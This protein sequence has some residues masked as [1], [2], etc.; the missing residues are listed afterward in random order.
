MWDYTEWVFDDDS[1]SSH[2]FIRLLPTLIKE[3]KIIEEN[4]SLF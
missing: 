4:F 1:F 3:L 2:L